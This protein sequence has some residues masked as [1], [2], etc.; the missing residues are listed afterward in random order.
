MCE[1]CFRI[2]WVVRLTPALAVA[3]W[4]LFVPRPNFSRL[5]S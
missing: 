1:G 2:A 4:R 3:L 5:R